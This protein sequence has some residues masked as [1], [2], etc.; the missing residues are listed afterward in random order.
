MTWSIENDYLTKE[1]QF[2][3]FTEAIN[4]MNKISPISEKANHHPDILVHDY[5]KVKIML[6]THS[7]KQ[8]TDKDY[9][10]AKEIDL[11]K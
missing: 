9:Q 5:N 8:I 2:A 6:Q 4:F 11:I 7:E 3:N 10:L 1:F